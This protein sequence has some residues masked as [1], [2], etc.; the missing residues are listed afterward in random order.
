[1][2]AR[3]DDERAVVIRDV[4]DVEPGFDAGMEGIGVEILLWIRLL[5]LAGMVNDVFQVEEGN[6]VF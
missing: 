5:R 4:V 3:D 6:P 2:R 1:M